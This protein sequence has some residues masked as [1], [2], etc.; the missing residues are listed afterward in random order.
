MNDIQL[1]NTYAANNGNLTKTT[2]G[3]GAYIENVYD[4]LDRIVQIKY[5]GSIKYKYAYN[6]NGD[7][8]E[9]EDV[10]NNIKYRYEYDSLDRLCSSYTMVGT[11]IKVVS[12]Y[13]YD[14]KS[15]VTE[16]TCGMAGATGGSLG[17]TYGYV[18]D[19]TNGTMSSMTVTASGVSDTLSFTYD[20]LQRNC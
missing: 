17:Q 8:C 20:A 15:R 2:Y 18:Y 9:I 14:G 7:L 4:V 11:S 12:D 1:S 19:D 5:N 6:G 16:Y 3:N 13:T 10:A